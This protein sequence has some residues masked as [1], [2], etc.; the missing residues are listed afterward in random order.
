MV[1]E[2]LTLFFSGMNLI[3]KVASFIPFNPLPSKSLCKQA[4]GKV[5]FPSVHLRQERGAI[6]HCNNFKVSVDKKKSFFLGNHRNTKE[7][8]KK[9]TF[10]QYFFGSFTVFEIEWMA[11]KKKKKTYF[12]INSTSPL[13][14]FSLK[15]TSDYRGCDLFWELWSTVNLVKTSLSYSM[16]V[17]L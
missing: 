7:E 3:S 9:S 1:L 8:R 6:C 5:V 16:E 2:G 14:F 13:A 12:G 15:Q 4:P 17:F 10:Q 11:R